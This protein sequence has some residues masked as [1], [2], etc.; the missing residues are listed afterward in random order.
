[1]KLLRRLIKLTVRWL[2]DLGFHWPILIKVM[3]GISEII[4][5]NLDRDPIA[6][7]LLAL[8]PSRFRND[9]EILA[10]T[11]KI[12]I[13]TLDKSALNLL[14]NLYYDGLKPQYSEL[15]DSTLNPLIAS[16][17]TRFH[18][19]LTSF[20]ATLYNKLA[21][22]AVVSAAYYYAQEQDIALV[23]EKI[24]K[25][26][27]VLHKENLVTTDMNRKDI[28]RLC[29]AM[30]GFKGSLLITHNQAVR[31]TMLDCNF[32]DPNKIKA[33]GC[34]RMDKFIKRV[35]TEEQRPR[36]KKRVTLFSFVHG[37]GM[38][39]VLNDFSPKRNTGFVRLFEETHAGIVRL[40][41]NNPDIDFVIKP[42]WLG[43]YWSAEIDHAIKLAG[44]IPGQ[45]PN[46]IVDDTLDAQE[47]IIQSDLVVSLRLPLL[48]NKL[49]YPCFKKRWI[50]TIRNS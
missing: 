49:F 16:R 8:N 2:G 45:I 7:I 12:R 19:Y 29:N 3:T 6:P 27:I 38:S 37:N 33:L 43:V 23:S 31:N 11:G 14:T 26:W 36:E 28:T 18:A 4:V 30:K 32:A 15:H 46:L 40:A 20:L 9:L 50:P 10:E 48:G 24:G 25:P 1:M 42:K 41:M 13:L 44:G 47:L 22:D 34:L 21:I 5:A 17:Q 35:K 39:G